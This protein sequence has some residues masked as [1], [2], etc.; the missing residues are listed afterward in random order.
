[1]S[2]VRSY[3]C[4]R[5]TSERHSFYEG[6]VCWKSVKNSQSQ[7]LLSS[8]STETGGGGAVSYPVS[9][10][11][12]FSTQ[13]CSRTRLEVFR[14]EGKSPTRTNMEIQQESCMQNNTS[15]INLDISSTRRVEDA[16]PCKTYYN[17]SDSWRRTW[18]WRGGSFSEGC[19]WHAATLEQQQVVG[20]ALTAETT[21]CSRREQLVLWQP[22][23]A[24]EL[25]MLQ[26][27]FHCNYR[28]SCIYNN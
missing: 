28:V 23:C 4:W 13:T 27:A 22:A 7:V 14:L 18:W 6:G 2:R 21:T 8:W 19:C 1:M 3:L 11:T 20:S 10:H 16:Y 15:C 26:L 17:M 9:T 24:M 5:S 12:F 25:K